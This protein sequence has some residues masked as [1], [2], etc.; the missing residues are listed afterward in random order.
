MSAEFVPLFPL[1]PPRSE[2]ATFSPLPPKPAVS[3]AGPHNCANAS[4]EV[5]IEVKRDDG[6]ISQ[7][8]LHCRCGEL[9]EIDCEY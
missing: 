8:R 4:S 5:K 2:G 1:Q 3:V 7:I 9:I 6:R